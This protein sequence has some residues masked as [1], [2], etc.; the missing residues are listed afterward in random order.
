MGGTL[1][2]DAPT[3]VVR[4][5]DFDL[6]DALVQ[7]EFC[8]V[9][10]SRQMGK[11]S[12]LMRTKHRLKESGFQ[13]SALDLTR[14]GSHNVTPLQWYKGIFVEL[15]RGFG[16]LGR[17]NLNQWWQ[18]QEGVSFVQRLSV[19]LEDLLTDYFPEENL[20][21]FIDEVDK[22]LGLEFTV[23]DF[24]G[25]IRS[26]YN[27]RASHP[28][29]KRLTFAIFGVADPSNLINDPVT[30]PFNIGKAISLD[31]FQWPEIRPLI[32]GLRDKI[33]GDDEAI[34]KAILAW[35]GGQPF[36][37][38]K[39]CSLIDRRLKN[40]GTLLLTPGLEADWVERLVRTRIIDN[41]TAQD[42]PEHLRTIRDRLEAHGEITIR[43][44]SLYQKILQ[45]EPCSLSYSGG[46][47]GDNRAEVE[48]LLSGLV[49]RRHGHLKVKNR[50]YGEVFNEL[51]IEEQLA[52][53][54]PYSQAFSLWMAT[55]RQ[56]NHHLLR[57]ELLRSAKTWAEGKSL[58]DWDYQFLARS[59]EC[60]RLEA[61]T[62]L[63]SE[64]ASAIAAKLQEE[65]KRLGQEKKTAHLQRLLL[66]AISITLIIVSSLTAT[67][68]GQY[69][70]ALEREVEAVI[71]SSEALFASHQG[72]DALVEALR[73]QTQLEHL[74]PSLDLATQERADRALR[75]AIY[76][77]VESNRLTGHEASIF[78]ITFSPDGRT[79]ATASGDST[80]KIWSSQGA[81]LQSLVG[82]GSVVWDVAFSPDGQTLVSG[83]DDNTARLWD[84]QGHLLQTFW[85]HDAGVFD[86]DI[87]PDGM[88]IATASA[89]GTVR[90]WD[91]EG[92][93][94]N[95]IPHRAGVGVRNVT[96]APDGQTLAT[97][98]T[99]G[100]AQLWSLNGDFLQTFQG[101]SSAVF[102]VAFSPNG[103]TIVTASGDRTLKLWDRSGNLITTIKGHRGRIW[104]VAFS[105]DGETIASGSE[106]QTIKL[107]NLEGTLLRTLQGHTASIK[108]LAF[109]PQGTILA[110][111]GS[112][113]IA[114]LWN[115]NNSLL[116][117]FY[118][119]QS[120]IM[121][122]GFTPD[123]Q[124]IFTGSLD[125]TLRLWDLNG[126]PQQVL[127]IHN[128]GIVD[129][130]ISLNGSIMVSTGVDGIIN[131]WTQEGQLLKTLKNSGSKTRGIAVRPD[132]QLIAAG[133]TNGQV[134]LWRQT[135]EKMLH[136]KAHDIAIWDVAFNPSGD[137]LAT[138]SGDNTVKIWTLDG[139][140]V[141]VLEGHGAAVMGVKFSPD[142]QVVATNS[143]DRTI[144]LWTLDGRLIRTLRGH[145]AQ[146]WDMA[147]SPDAHLLA[148]ASADKTVKLWEI[149][150]GK[151]LKTLNVHSAGVRGVAFS[152]DGNQVMSV[153]DDQVGILW[154]LNRLLAL[155]EAAYACDWLQDYVTTNPDMQPYRS[156][157]ND[158]RL[159]P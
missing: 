118:G 101:H 125:Q 78:A 112:E 81:L 1:T 86:V 38:Q 57:G 61:Q 30:T 55:K 89:D 13:C 149:G 156:L 137:L 46:A 37:T 115:I 121:R 145:R 116:T 105:P 19:F 45:G 95:I 142:G 59:E 26:C 133:D 99:D 159:C 93:L 85:G 3:Y 97:A 96:F 15:C 103:Q 132:G 21:I 106:D 54:R 27:Y 120:G 34:F 29:Y 51:W 100:T 25:M 77:A 50:I 24:F 147:F 110:S 109:N 42:E 49:I 153:G 148:T 16:L 127:R 155:D 70:Q 113:Y 56:D 33:E 130:G 47:S 36:L 72:L 138:A 53:R 92:T 66:V 63:E 90:L 65:Q 4:Q 152:P 39:V 131:I 58:G 119:H 22:I 14:I 143:V 107:W 7:G 83:S 129:L 2:L 157:Q 140:L 158:R 12:L 76:S 62:I 64:R 88:T 28:N 31:G 9:L 123:G 23:A 69:Y 48:L 151:L 135:G 60:D 128:A 17:F 124:H 74:V 141:T 82:H 84:L 114:K 18:A 35:T 5:A 79:I 80:V 10:N 102:D 87:S 117:R 111:A 20:V 40:E 108:T 68:F 67:A 139:E 136:F 146:V 44:L 104:A 6:Y 91:R 122:V 150:S 134:Q 8:Y 126:K 43:L 52:Q 144:K 32:T 154:N 75:Q 98:S 11:S 41:W 71:T 73:A 94:L